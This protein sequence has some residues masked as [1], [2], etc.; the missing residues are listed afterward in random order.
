MP[1]PAEEA[2]VDGVMRLVNHFPDIQV[3]TTKTGL[4]RSLHAFYRDRGLRVFDHTPTTFIIKVS[5]IQ[6]H[7]SHKVGRARRGGRAGRARGA[8]PDPARA[9]TEWHRFTR[10]FRQLAQRQFSHECLPA[11]HCQRNVWIVKPSHLNQGR[12]IQ[13]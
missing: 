10:H 8:T 5:D 9:Q 3:L 7:G 1:R 6:T 4:V 2:A 12:G 11:K 13:V